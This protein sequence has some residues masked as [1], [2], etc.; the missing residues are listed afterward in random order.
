LAGN[1]N[2]K[3]VFRKGLQLILIAVTTGCAVYAI[4][5]TNY[6]RWIDSRGNPVHSDRPPPK[7]VDYEVVSTQSTFTRAVPAEEGAVP[8][9]VEP[10]VGNEFNQEDSSE[11]E[12]NKKNIELCKR[13][14]ANM[15]AL[16]ASDTVSMRNSEG[17]VER[18]DSQE[19]QV[20]RET[21][22]AQIQV[23]CED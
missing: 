16:T 6:Y 22:M 9:Q 8:A 18:L 4:A 3:P 20:Q 1:A 14:R 7:G 12:R 15:E 17:E 5:D 11:H 19:L 23:Y 13:A 21:T 2:L 10:S